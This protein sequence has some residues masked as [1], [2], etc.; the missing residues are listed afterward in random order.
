MEEYKIRMIEEKDDLCLKILKLENFIDS[1]E[2]YYKLTFK[3][4]L[5]MAMQYCHMKKYLKY[6]MKRIDA[7][8]T[9][10]ELDDYLQEK[11]DKAK[12]MKAAKKA[13]KTPK[14]KKKN[15]TK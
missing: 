12:K 10:D 4:K 6:L 11:A 1:N 15:E 5:Y 14:T 2:D 8:I 13:S 9:Q 3:N 7:N